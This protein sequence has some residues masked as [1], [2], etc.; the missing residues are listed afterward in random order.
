MSEVIEFPGRH[1]RSAE[2]HIIDAENEMHDLA[3]DL[4]FA[5]WVGHPRSEWEVQVVSGHHVAR[6][7]GP[8]R[9]AAVETAIAWMEARR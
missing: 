3:Y 1:E 5:A 7:P 9:L 4:G 6:I 8:S 2:S